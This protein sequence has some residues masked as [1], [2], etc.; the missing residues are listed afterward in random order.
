[1]EI[2]EIKQHLSINTILK[3]Y[4]LEC[5]CNYRLRFPFHDDKTP[6]LQV[7]PKTGTWSNIR[8]LPSPIS[9]LEI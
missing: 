5:N 6:S 3:H 4:R 9:I 2:Q 8:F 1:M 7:Y